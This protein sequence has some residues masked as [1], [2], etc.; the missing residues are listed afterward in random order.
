[1]RIAKRVKRRSV[2][3][4]WVYRFDVNGNPVRVIVY[5]CSAVRVDTKAYDDMVL[6]YKVTGGQARPVL[7]SGQ[8]DVHVREDVKPSGAKYLEVWVNW[9][10]D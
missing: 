5:K 7:K 10:R 2:F 3:N 1:M 6:T 4:G 8:P 9:L